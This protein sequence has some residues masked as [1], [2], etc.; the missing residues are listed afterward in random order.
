MLLKNSHIEEYLL[1]WRYQPKPSDNVNK[2]LKKYN[3]DEDV[4]VLQSK[5]EGGKRACVCV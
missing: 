3:R 1:V 5:G 4:S 2:K